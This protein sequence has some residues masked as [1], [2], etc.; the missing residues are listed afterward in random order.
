M[1]IRAVFCSSLIFSA[2]ALC[3]SAT[4]YTPKAGFVPDSKT[5][6]AVAEAVLTP[7]YGKEQIESE[8]PFTATLKQGVWTIEGTK[9]LRCQRS[10]DN[11]LLGWCSRGEDIEG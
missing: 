1:R 5:A 10:K 4:S 8:R 9:L 2:W 3:Q 7:I 6:V 11:G